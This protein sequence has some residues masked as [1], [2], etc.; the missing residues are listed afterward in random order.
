MILSL[1]VY[2]F[3]IQFLSYTI[4]GLTGF[5]NPLLSNPLMAM[6]LDNRVITPANL[7]LDLPVNIYMV[8][9]NREALD[10]KIVL[11]VAMWI[12]AGVVPGTL[13][14]KLGSPWV[15]KALLGIV[16][17]GLGVEMLTRDSIKKSKDYPLLRTVISVSSGIMAGLFGIN[18][19][20]LSY[21]ERVSA[22]RQ[23][24]RSNVCFVFLLENIF[25]ILLYLVN[26]MFTFYSLQIT[27]IS[28]PAAILGVWCGSRIDKSMQE[29][30]VKYFIIGIFILGGV[31]ILIKALVFRA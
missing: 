23:Q 29:R 4:K 5:G 9:K 31:S 2:L 21:F 30:T 3:I 6:K 27:L 17:I 13:F 25:R 19:L 10:L 22:D 8:W 20:F 11:P 16:I 12:M 28:I 1:A 26:G 24:F 7:L 18:M 15:I 14:L